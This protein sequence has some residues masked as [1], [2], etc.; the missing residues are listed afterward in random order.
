MK[1][2]LHFDVS[3]PKTKHFFFSCTLWNRTEQ[4]DYQPGNPEREDFKL[5]ME[6]KNTN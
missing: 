4:I 3:D 6:L 2:S 5:K 1:K